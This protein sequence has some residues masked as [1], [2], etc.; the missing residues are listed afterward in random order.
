MKFNVRNSIVMLVAGVLAV[1]AQ[2]VGFGFTNWDDPAYIT[3]NPLLSKFD[4]NFLTIIFGQPLHGHY[5]PLTWISLAFDQQLFGL[6]AWG[7]HLHNLMLHLANAL[8]VFYLIRLIKNDIRIAFFTAFV[9]AIHPF[10]NESVS[11]ITERKNLL[12]TLFY[13]AS[14][15]G[16]IQYYKKQHTIYYIVSFVFFLL[17]LLSKGAA[18]TLPIILLLWHV[19]HHSL[20]KKEIIKLLPFFFLTLIFS[21]LA[22]KAQ[23]PLLNQVSAKLTLEHSLLYSSWAFGLYV[24]KAFI[25]FQLAAFH[26]IFLDNVAGYYSLGFIVLIV[27]II[28]MIKS[29]KQHKADLF[30]GLSFFFVNIVLFLKVFDA[31]ASSYFMAERYTYL[32]FVGLFFAFFSWYFSTVKKSIWHNLLIVWILM[33]GVLSFQYAQKWK[34]S[35]LLWSNVLSIYPTSDVALL[36]YGNALRQEKQYNKA[37]ES[38]NKITKNGELYYKMLENRA[39]VYYKTNQWNEAVGDYARLLEKYPQRKNIKQI[40]AGILINQGNLQLA[41]NQLQFLL[42]EDSTLCDAW[43]SLGNYYSQTNSIDSALLAYDKAINCGNKAL[44]Y[45]NKATLLSIN[46]R[47]KEAIPYF[48][49]A[50]TLDSN[51]SNYYANRAINYFKLKDYPLAIRDFSKAILLNPQNVD[52]YLNRSNVFMAI[53]Q[54]NNAISDLSFAIKLTPHDGDTYA[55]RSFVYN[56]MGLTENACNDIQK[57]IQ[58]GYRKYESWAKQICK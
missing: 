23:Q 58:L 41:Y 6:N 19:Y 57:A 31:Y 52:H 10:A 53:N 13:L 30:F 24:V 37:I 47:I 48:N 22:I 40:I 17:S 38:Y 8:I 54:W 16:Y 7:F 25:P 21:W 36:N 5:H 15:V 35:S 34:N 1:F 4:F 26:P 27:Y 44:Y 2:T 43:N 42:K 45:Y 56:K 12:F 51:Q 49:K 46:N 14:F 50:I 55:R 39:F 29:L 9:F 32:A 20:S 33:L 18:I 3:Q 11:W 28:L